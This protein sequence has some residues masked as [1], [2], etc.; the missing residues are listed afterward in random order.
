[1]IGAGLERAAPV[2]HTLAIDTHRALVDLAVS[3]RS[4]CRKPALLQ[5]I[6]KAKTHRIDSEN[7]RHK[8]RR[9]CLLAK[10]RDEIRKRSLCGSRIVEARDDLL[11][12][13]DLDVAGIA[14]AST[15]RFNCAISASG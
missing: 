6:R 2:R 10:A 13:F 12:K 7:L 15:R 11:R 8:I 3:L 9:Q 1:M 4:A 5:D 14:A